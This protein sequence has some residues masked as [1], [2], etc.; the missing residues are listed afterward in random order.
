MVLLIDMQ[1]KLFPAMADS[2]SLLE[3]C[4]RFLKIAQELGVSIQ[5]TEQS[6]KENTWL[7]K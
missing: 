5:A 4:L 3:N 2:T 7:K 1:E 6:R